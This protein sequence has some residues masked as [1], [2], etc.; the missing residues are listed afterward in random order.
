MSRRMSRVGRNAWL[1]SPLTGMHRA[2][3][4]RAQL[5]QS[6][7]DRIEEG[8]PRRL[9]RIFCYGAGWKRSEMHI[10]NGKRNNVKDT[11]ENVIRINISFT[12]RCADGWALERRQE[13]RSS[14]A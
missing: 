9:A 10:C 3:K 12:C 1:E 8:Q 5:E 2:G 13:L 14:G 6:A 4:R 11:G 7:Q